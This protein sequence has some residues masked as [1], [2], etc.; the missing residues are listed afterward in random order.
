MKF[1]SCERI[2][3]IGTPILFLWGEADKL[4]PKRHMQG[5]IDLAYKE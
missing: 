3:N 1:P 2:G 4:V 5:L